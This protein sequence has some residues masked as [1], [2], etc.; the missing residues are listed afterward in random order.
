ME[1]ADGKGPWYRFID[2]LLCLCKGE[3]MSR[4]KLWY[5]SYAPGVPNEID[6]ETITMP[7]VIERTSRDF[8]DN[9]ALLYTGTKI[10]FKE[11]DRP[12]NCFTGAHDGMVEKIN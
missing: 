7:D 2:Y 11:F 4:E 10:L 3:I 12:A 1:P 9:I 8:P 6:L 5:K